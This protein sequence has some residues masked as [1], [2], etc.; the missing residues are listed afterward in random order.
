M[1]DTA[2]VVLSP[3]DQV[4]LEKV[5]MA[6]RRF[7][8]GVV[9]AP[10]LHHVVSAVRDVANFDVEVPTASQH[11][12]WELVKVGVKRL[13]VWYMRYLAEQLNNFGNN[14]TRLGDALVARTEALERADDEL[15]ARVGA[16]EERLARLEARVLGAHG[17]ATRAAGTQGP[18]AP[19]GAV[20]TG[21]AAAP[22]SEAAGVGRATAPVSESA[23]VGRP[24][25]PGQAADVGGPMAPV[26][27]ATGPRGPMAPATEVHAP[28]SGVAPRAASGGP[29]SAKPGRSEP[30][31]GGGHAKRASGPGARP[32]GKGG[33]GGK[34]RTN[35]SRP[36]NEGT[37]K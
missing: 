31:N 12:E 10:D 1:P 20:G 27:E 21:A 36:R 11:R 16:A 5:R 2:E 30:G 22:V 37:S 18:T 4:Y 6:S 9:G 25:A 29:P 13:S 26:S 35:G 34:P 19:G 24:A 7:R 23:G 33:K 28:A 15:A 32:G 14:V 17:D 3:A 8:A